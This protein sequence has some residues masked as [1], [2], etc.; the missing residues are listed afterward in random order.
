MRCACMVPHACMLCAYDSQ[1]KSH[2][3]LWDQL[4]Y[5]QYTWYRPDNEID[6]GQILS[7]TFVKKQQNT[8][9]RLLFSSNIREA[10]KVVYAKWYFKIDGEECKVPKTIEILLFSDRDNLLHIPAVLLG[11]CTATSA[12]QIGKG[13]HSISVHVKGSSALSG[14]FSTSFLEIKEIC[15]ENQ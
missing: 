15:T 5:K 6:N 11:T 7:V 1:W 14:H 4:G 13:R 8:G 12:G 2:R 3:C 9:L 10:H